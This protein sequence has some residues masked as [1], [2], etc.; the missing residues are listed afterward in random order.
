VENRRG[1]GWGR[2]IYTRGVGR[3]RARRR[4]CAKSDLNLTKA[5]KKS[6]TNFMGMDNSKKRCRGDVRGMRE[7]GDG[8]IRDTLPGWL[9]EPYYRGYLNNGT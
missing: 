2:S 3:K 1:K 5:E 8:N 9:R 4:E 6:D 7:G